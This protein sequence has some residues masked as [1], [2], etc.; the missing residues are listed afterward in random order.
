MMEWQDEFSN[1]KKGKGNQISGRKTLTHGLVMENGLTNGMAIGGFT[2]GNA[3]KGLT[4][5]MAT[6]N[7][8]IK[9]DFNTDFAFRNRR[10]GRWKISFA[11]FLT[12]IL[13]ATSIIVWTNNPDSIHHSVL[14]DNKYGEWT[15]LTDIGFAN[16]GIK[17]KQNTLYMTLKRD[18]ILKG[19]GNITESYLIFINDKTSS[20]GYHIGYD[21]YEYYI[22]IFGTNNSIESA[23]GSRFD[24]NKNQSDWN[25]FRSR[26]STFNIARANTQNQME[27]SLHPI[28]LGNVNISQL[29]MLLFHYDTRGNYE[30]S[31]VIDVDV[32]KQVELSE[33]GTRSEPRIS[34]Y[35]VFEKNELHIVTE[36]A[37]AYRSIPYEIRVIKDTSP[38]DIDDGEPLQPNQQAIEPNE[39]ES[40]DMATTFIIT[41]E[42]DQQ[43]IIKQC[44]GH[45]YE[46][47][48]TN[49]TFTDNEIVLYGINKTVVTIEFMGDFGLRYI[50]EL[51]IS[52]GFSGLNLNAIPEISPRQTI[53]SNTEL[54]VRPTNHPVTID[55]TINHDTHNEWYP[56]EYYSVNL[57]ED[58]DNAVMKDEEY[59]YAYIDKHNEYF[60]NNGDY[61]EI[62]FDLWNA[63]STSPNN[64]TYKK[65]RIDA[66]DTV[67]YYEG[68][69]S[70]WSSTTIPT[71]WTC[72]NHYVGFHQRYEFKV[73]LSDLSV[74]G[75][76]DEHGDKIGYGTHAYDVQGTDNVWYPAHYL[77]GNPPATQYEN[78]PDEWA[79]IIYTNYTM[80]AEGTSATITMDGKLD[81]SAW[82]DD[83]DIHLIDETQDMKVYTMM[84]DTYVYVGV[85]MTTDTTWDAGDFC[86]VAFDRNNGGDYYAQTDD[87][88][89]SVSGD[90]STTYYEGTGTG[91]SSKTSNWVEMKVNK[92]GST[93]TY[94]FRFEVDDLNNYSNFDNLTDEI[95]FMV[96]G[97]DG[98]GGYTIQYPDYYGG[99]HDMSYDPQC[100]G[101]LQR[102]HI[103]EFSDYIA[104]SMFM[105]IV[106][107]AFIKKRRDKDGGDANE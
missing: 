44:G 77:T 27:F 89:C 9:S 36:D 81:E 56:S 106:G 1:K 55:G 14:I 73:P 59:F 79:D 2:N 7:P 16:F 42:F 71:G 31:Q 105:L 101:D 49:Y 82:T 39:Y 17:E 94:E 33:E 22:D 60:N 30:Y 78:K 80:F 47:T 103:P 64:S 37:L 76:W 74:S 67:T 40:R 91:W 48:V 51:G 50:Q 58:T 28:Q 18:N 96:M 85:N 25:G 52:S 38:T 66:T 104:M 45:I 93:M 72:A 70:G 6:D 34:Y 68:S 102:V 54:E 41:Y 20:Y 98:G 90:N 69:G 53:G 83:A 12:F 88:L 107:M 87:V 13:I 21:T 4:N 15:N 35:H 62:Y 32:I 57:A 23:M 3:H 24:S 26:Y 11:L 97:T 100:W 29:E 19:N 5:G 75:S 46:S 61:G 43:D 84:D 86:Q 92:T 65:I 99:S 95:G 10:K 63:E 8:V